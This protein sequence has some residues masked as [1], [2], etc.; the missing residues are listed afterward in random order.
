M[1]IGLVDTLHLPIVLAGTLAA[2]STSRY[3]GCL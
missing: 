1:P 3:P 2:Y